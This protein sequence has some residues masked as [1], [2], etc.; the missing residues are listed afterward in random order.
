[1]GHLEVVW[2]EERVQS[3]VLS[4]DEVSHEAQAVV[5]EE[6]I[7]DSDP[8]WSISDE[9]GGSSVH[10]PIIIV[11][12]NSSNDLLISQNRPRVVLHESAV[13]YE[14]V[15]IV[16]DIYGTLHMRH[17]IVELVSQKVVWV[18]LAVQLVLRVIS[19]IIAIGLADNNHLIFTFR[20]I[21]LK[22][23][24]IKRKLTKGQKFEE[25]CF[26]FALEKRVRSRVVEEVDVFDV[27]NRP[28]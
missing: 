19:L 5:P 14:D 24:I 13:P 23:Q 3:G 21:L 27:Q 9:N 16:L 12:V 10:V 15:P 20:S 25:R 4:L 7:V 6:A 26:V 1:V 18:V 2:R 11:V 22:I 17:L 28:L 8:V